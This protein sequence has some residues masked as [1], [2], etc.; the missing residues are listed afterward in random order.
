MS[1]TLIPVS[2]PVSGDAAFA[3][4][5]P[6]SRIDGRETI[7]TTAAGDIERD[8][9]REAVM[10]SLFSWRRA[11]DEQAPSRQ[12]QGWHGD[13]T[14]GSRLWLLFR[15]G[16]A[17]AAAVAEARAHC[18]EALGWLVADGI[19]ARVDVEVT[20]L[21]RG[22]EVA[23]AVVRPTGERLDYRWGPLWG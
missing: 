12:R 4:F 23:V 1:E 17:D 2:V 11:A 16:R 7:R 8:V 19:A 14:M 20:R 15:R 13:P 5:T 21:E 18:V 6:A 22:I 3:L 9:L 10:V